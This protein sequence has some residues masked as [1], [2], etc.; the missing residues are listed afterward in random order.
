MMGQQGQ[1]P[2]MG[3][4]EGRFIDSV[5]IGPLNI[6]PRIGV[7]ETEEGIG[8]DVEKKTG[9]SNIGA[10]IMLDIG[11]GIYGKAEYDKGRT[12]EDIYFEGEK[13]L[14]N[15]PFDH[16]IWEIWWWL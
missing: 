3:A 1:Q 6:N 13:V 11:K 16:D 12:S 10:D 9:S 15:I 14:E 5:G 7:L 2:R 4:A 8:P